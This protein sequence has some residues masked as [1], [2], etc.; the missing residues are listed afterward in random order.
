[1]SK[2]QIDH[3]EQ[4][5]KFCSN[6]FDSI[7]DTK[8]VKVKNLGSEEVVLKRL[9]DNDLYKLPVKI[10]EPP[11]ALFYKSNSFSAQILHVGH[12]HNRAIIDLINNKEI[13]YCS[14]SISS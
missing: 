13:N 11:Q 5:K 7:V 2:T 10:T 12:F 4:N 8:K 3:S 14:K 1:M 6:N 9:E